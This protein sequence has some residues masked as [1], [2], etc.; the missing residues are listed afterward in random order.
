M[1]PGFINTK[2]VENQGFPKFLSYAASFVLPI[3]ATDPSKPAELI[4]ELLTSPKYA[5]PSL[6][7][8]LVSPNGK[9]ASVKEI[10]Q[11]EGNKVWEYTNALLASL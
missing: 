1:F 4:V 6:N 9:V 8:G 11:E 7:G 10:N 2:G 3:L 5:D